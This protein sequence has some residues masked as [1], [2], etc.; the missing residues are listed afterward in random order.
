M[1]VADFWDLLNLAPVQ[2]GF[3]ALPAGR[4][5]GEREGADGGKALKEKD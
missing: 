1:N 5:P 3:I 2:R 4:V